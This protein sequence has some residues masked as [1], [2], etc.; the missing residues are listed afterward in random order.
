MKTDKELFES[1]L[2]KT[3]YDAA[4]ITQTDRLK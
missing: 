1:M 2:V 3:E 4:Y